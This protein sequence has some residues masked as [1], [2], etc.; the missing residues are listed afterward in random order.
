MSSVLLV[1]MTGCGEN[2]ELPIVTSYPAYTPDLT[3]TSVSVTPVV[4]APTITKPTSVPTPMPTQLSKV[5]STPVPATKS[6]KAEIAARERLSDSLGITDQVFIVY[7]TE[8]LDWY[9]AS[10]GCP[11]PGYSYAQVITPGYRI[12]FDMEGVHYRVHTNL[13]GSNTILC[14]ETPV[15]TSVV[16]IQTPTRLPITITVVEATPTSKLLAITPPTP[17][18]GPT[19]T[20]T[21]ATFQIASATSASAVPPTLAPTLTPTVRPKPLFFFIPT[22][23][24]APIPTPVPAHLQNIRIELA[25][26][27]LEFQRLTNLAQ[28]D[29]GQ[30]N[31]FVTEQQGQIHVFADD[32][33]TT[34]SEVFLDIRDRVSEASNEEG[35]LGFTFDTEYSTNGHFYVYYSASSPRRSVISRFSV[36]QNNPNIAD[37]LSETIMM[38]IPQPYSNHNGG[39]IAF[40]PDGYLYIGLGDGGSGGDPIGN[41]QNIS[42][43]LGTILR[44]DVGSV[45]ENKSYS[46]P[47]DNPFVGISGVREE[48]WA[49]GLRNPWRFSFDSATGFLW[50]GD[51][52]QNNW[53]EVDIVRKGLNYGWNT[54]EGTH[55]FPSTNNCD[56]TNLELPVYE[57]RHTE[58][59]SISGGYVYR[60]NEIPWLI[61]TYIY[62]DFCS[63]KIW[64]LRYDGESVI[65][66][67]LLLDSAL[68]I[69][70]FGQGLDNK[71]YVLSRDDGIYSILPSE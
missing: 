67:S 10:L 69:T 35:L 39:Q 57:Y 6:G 56:T 24:A 63:G 11:K 49:Y 27:N 7:R 59:C 18:L 32:L 12:T 70:S 41:G 36:S 13:D 23:T 17:T 45:S 29:D 1:L 22:P 42:T 30:N 64:G 16:A 50:A 58:G 4:T 8:S 28:P 44:I 9:D 46:I 43:V 54:M 15:P 51:V 53:E 62:G 2:K 40:G 71:L 19:L 14:N 26:H 34:Q 55:C 38:E 68:S 66:H 61:G 52:G 20:A 65:E 5:A 21:P 3:Y 33:E 60:G 37:P 25:F 48:I 47:I 31:I